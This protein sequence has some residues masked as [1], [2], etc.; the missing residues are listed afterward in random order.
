MLK[1]YDPGTG[2]W[3]SV[4]ATPVSLIDPTTCGNYEIGPAVTRS[5]GTGGLQ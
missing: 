4:A 3:A 5:G 2:L 1:Q